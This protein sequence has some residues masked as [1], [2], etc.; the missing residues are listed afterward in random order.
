MTKL[1]I[2]L[3]ALVFSSLTC[4][5]GESPVPQNNEN[6]KLYVSAENFN[7]NLGKYKSGQDIFLNLIIYNAGKGQQRILLPEQ[8][9]RLFGFFFTVSIE[10]SD[11][12]VSPGGKVSLLSED[13]RY[14]TLNYK[15]MFG[16]KINLLDVFPKLKSGKYEVKIQYNNQYGKDC[17]KGTLLA[18]KTIPI[19][20]ISL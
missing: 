5:S 10:G 18:K 12:I 16:I 3:V 2:L 4:M 1:R 19:E 7:D 6:L 9:P 15:E 13:Y 11:S 20:I 8:W 17:F 14:I